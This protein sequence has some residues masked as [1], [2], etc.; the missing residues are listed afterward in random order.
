[1]EHQCSHLVSSVQQCIQSV[2]PAAA[3]YVLR[4]VS[5]VLVAALLTLLILDRR[6][7]SSQE[8]NHNLSL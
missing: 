4:N 3:S 2:N 1:M 6:R 5:S 8:T 7:I